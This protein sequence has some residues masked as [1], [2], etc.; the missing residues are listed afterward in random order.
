M[1]EIVAYIAHSVDG[2]IADRAGSL[3]WLKPFDTE[4]YGWDAFYARI[5][6]VVMGSTTYRDLRR[7]GDWP[8]RGKAA[9]VMTSGPRIDEDGIAVFDDRH[10]VD[11]AVD[12]ERAGLRR[13]WIVG[14]GGPIRTFLDAGLVRR[15]HLFQ[16]PVVLGGGTPLWRTGSRR[17]PLTLSRATTWANGVV[18]TEYLI[19]RDGAP[20]G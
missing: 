8:Y 20:G 15:L 5:D 6:A 17:W 19:G 3:D 7:L 12:L 16:M 4:D 10:A 13:V 2:F 18:E 11:I 1:P 9:I 14:G